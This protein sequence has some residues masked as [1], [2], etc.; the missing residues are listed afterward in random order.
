M[1][2]PSTGLEWNT[3]GEHF[4]THLE[5]G[6]DAVERLLE[7]IGHVLLEDEVPG[8]REAVAARECGNHP[9]PLARRDEQ[10]AEAERKRKPD[11]VHAASGAVG[12]LA[13]KIGIE[14][15]KRR[16]APQLWCS[17]IGRHGLCSR[18]LRAPIPHS[19]P[20][21]RYAQ[22]AIVATARL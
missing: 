22:L 11:E 5:V 10:R 2:C 21:G 19:P 12:M 20:R 7:R 17:P 6:H 14:V 8:K 1:T 9:R 16:I 13:Q 3:T 18:A 4:E 15:G